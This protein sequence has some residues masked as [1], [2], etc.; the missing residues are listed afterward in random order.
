MDLSAPGILQQKGCR[1]ATFSMGLVVKVGDV[2]EGGIV[3]I[4]KDQLSHLAFFVY[5]DSLE[6]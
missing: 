4:Q 6:G 2:I 3:F 5:M 1:D